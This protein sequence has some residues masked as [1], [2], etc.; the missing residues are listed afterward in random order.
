MSALRLQLKPS[1]PYLKP[2]PFLCFLL[3]STEWKRLGC[4]RHHV[5]SVGLSNGGKVFRE[6]DWWLDM[7]AV[8]TSLCH[9]NT[10]PRS[11]SG[12]VLPSVGTGWDSQRHRSPAGHDPALYVVSVWGTKYPLPVK[13]A[14]LEN[15]RWLCSSCPWLK[16][17]KMTKMCCPVFCMCGYECRVHVYL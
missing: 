12:A 17:R 6:G 1:K 14:A 3:S 13:A 7:W 8:K 16:W 9:G 4:Y 10:S 11:V 15:Q 5:L 2:L